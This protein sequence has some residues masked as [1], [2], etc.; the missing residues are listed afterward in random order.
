MSASFALDDYSNTSPEHLSTTENIT[1][2][3]GSP[4]DDCECMK[5]A[6]EESLESCQPV[7]QQPNGMNSMANLPSSKE[8]LNQHTPNIDSLVTAPANI[9]CHDQNTDYASSTTSNGAAS[10]EGL[11]VKMMLTI[12]LLYS[13]GVACLTT[14]V[15]FAYDIGF[16][17]PTLHDLSQNSGK[18]TYFNKTIYHDIFNV[19]D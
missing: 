14:M 4:T 17:S 6:T 13:S 7:Q 16:S 19:S 12:S 5:N 10:R 15:A 11:G 2:T 8:L 3:L 9:D 1:S 18:H